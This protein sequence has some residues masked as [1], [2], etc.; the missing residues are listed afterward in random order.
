MNAQIFQFHYKLCN[1]LGTPGAN[2]T[3]TQHFTHFSETTVQYDKWFGFSFI[4]HQV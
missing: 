4:V 3:E 1:I 2:A